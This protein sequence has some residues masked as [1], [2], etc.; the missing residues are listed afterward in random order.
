MNEITQTMKK[1]FLSK[2]VRVA[3]F[4]FFTLTIL[5]GLLISFDYSE[6]VVLSTAFAL[7]ISIPCLS[8]MRARSKTTS[9][10]IDAS[11]LNDIVYIYADSWA[12]TS[13]ALQQM[14]A[15]KQPHP[16]PANPSTSTLSAIEKAI[17]IDTIQYKDALRH[18][19]G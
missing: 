3:I 6:I 4:T 9:S 19:H 10:Q 15:Y 12:G 13:K 1:I 17:C 8:L 7:S 5:S 18:A 16:T 11:L 14:R 2:D